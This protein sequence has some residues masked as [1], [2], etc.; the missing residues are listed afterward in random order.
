MSDLSIFYRDKAREDSGFIPL[1]FLLIEVLGSMTDIIDGMT[2]LEA[3]KQ[4]VEG[5][6]A[7]EGEV[8]ESQALQLLSRLQAKESADE[9][10]GASRPAK[11]K[12]RTLGSEFLARFE[13][14]SIAEKCL[15]A[16]DYDY[17]KARLLYCV[18]DK[19]ISEKIISDKLSMEFDRM[20]VQFESV[21]LGMG[22][23]FK[24]GASSSKDFGEVT[25]FGPAPGEEG[26]LDAAQS[27]MQMQNSYRRG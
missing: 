14:M 6:G 1:T 5:A 3:V 9:N 15:Y 10:Q 22:G 25:E 19:D 7:Y 12:E 20:Q 8:S 17:A 11:R 4:A 24:K 18:Y 16:A 13:K 21:V 23:S 26:Y 2:L 27:F